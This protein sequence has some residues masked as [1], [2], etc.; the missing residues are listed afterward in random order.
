M[1]ILASFALYLRGLRRPI[2]WV[3]W[4]AAVNKALGAVA[5]GGWNGSRTAP[6]AKPS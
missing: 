3:R 6:V 5:W 2:A 1:R 4:S